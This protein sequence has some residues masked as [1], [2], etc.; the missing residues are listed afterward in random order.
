MTRAAKN[1]VTT[2]ERKAIP[3][4]ING[5]MNIAQRSTSVTGL[6]DGDEEYV[7]VDRFRHTA[8]ASSGRFTS[9]QTAVDDLDGFQ[10]F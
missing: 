2:P 5:D 3:L 8:A 10:N 1:R 7:T 4:V 9:K 6:G